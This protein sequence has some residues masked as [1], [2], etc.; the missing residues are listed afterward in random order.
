MPKIGEETRVGIDVGIGRS[1]AI[2]RGDLSGMY[3]RVKFN[4]EASDL[5]LFLE[6]TSYGF[7]LHNTPQGSISVGFELL[8]F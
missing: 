6:I 8:S 4:L 5:Q 2:G 7:Q 3:K 1:F